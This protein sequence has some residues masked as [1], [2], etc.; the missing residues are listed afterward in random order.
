MT[1]SSCGLVHL[2]EQAGDARLAGRRVLGRAFRDSTRLRSW[3]STIL[4]AASGTSAIVIMRLMISPRIGFSSVSST[5]A[6]VCGA[7]FDST[8][9]EVC[10]CSPARKAPSRAGSSFSSSGQIGGGP[11]GAGLGLSRRP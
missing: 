6:A 10:G 5:L 11:S 7:S 9:A 2:V 1:S 3:F 4:V 8:M